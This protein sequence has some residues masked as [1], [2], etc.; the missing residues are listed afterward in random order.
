[1]VA[2]RPL[3]DSDGDP[4]RCATAAPVPSRSLTFV[5]VIDDPSIASLKVTVGVTDVGAP[6]APSAGA[7]EA[8]V[9]AVA[10]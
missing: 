2:V 8:T 4:A 9:G 6:V 10:A 5:A 7:V 1:M 3:A